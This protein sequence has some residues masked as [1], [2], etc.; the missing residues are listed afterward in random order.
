MS[1]KEIDELQVK[2][3]ALEDKILFFQSTVELVKIVVPIILAGFAILIAIA[4][5]ERY[6]DAG[7][8]V[9]HELGSTA[10]KTKI[11]DVKSLYDAFSDRRNLTS[12]KF[13]DCALGAI[14]DSNSCNAGC[15]SGDQILVSGSCIVTDTAK[16]K[17]HLMNAGISDDGATWH[18]LWL[19]T[20][21]DPNKHMVGRARSL[22]LKIINAK[23]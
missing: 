4:Y 9:E 22:C 23:K 8:I 13:T 2:V 10:L 17:P 15:D 5:G 18:C 21:N 12:S 19:R 14:N 11:D 7:K 20:D 1:F 16:E 3:R 6:V